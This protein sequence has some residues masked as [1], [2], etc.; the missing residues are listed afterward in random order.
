MKLPW[1]DETNYWRTGKSSPD[2]WLDKAEAQIGKLGG[3]V[4]MRALGTDPMHGGEAF[5][6]VFE[7]EGEKFKL[8]WPVLPVERDKD[9]PSARRQAATLIYHDVKAKCLNAV[10]FG[11]RTAFFNYLLLPDN[12][13]VAELSLPE[14]ADTTPKML[15]GSVE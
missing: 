6:F 2:T 1:A 14:L 12:R 7:I 3:R 9:I 13:T 8:L 11:A 10:I 5:M 15:K 4:F